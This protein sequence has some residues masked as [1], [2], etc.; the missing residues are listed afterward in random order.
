MSELNK[1]LPFGIIVDIPYD[2]SITDYKEKAEAHEAMQE[3]LIR[4][5]LEDVKT[6]AEKIKNH[7]PLLK[8][9]RYNNKIRNDVRGDCIKVTFDFLMHG[10][11]W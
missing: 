3:A 9:I 4:L 10:L 8:I 5:I 2:S 11:E 6:V 1:I 7:P